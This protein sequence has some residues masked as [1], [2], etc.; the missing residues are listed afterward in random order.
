MENKYF[1][2]FFFF[3][4][5]LSLNTSAQDDE[6]SKSNI[7]TFTPSKLINKGQWDIKFFNGLY[8]QTKQTDEGSTSRTIPR[9][10]FF[11]STLEIFTGVSENNRISIGGILEFRSNT[12]NGRNAL[13]VFSFD[14][15]SGLSTIAPAIKW[16]PLENVGNFSIQTAL[17]IPTTGKEGQNEEFL[18]QSAWALQNRLFYDYT[19]PSGDWQIFTELNTEYNFGAEESFANNTLLLSPGLFLSYFPNNK[20]TV[21]VFSQHMQRL[22]GNFQQNGTS[23]GFGGKYQLTNVTNIEVLYNK[24]VRGNNFQGLGATYSIGLRFLF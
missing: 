11:T 21:L 19:F 23:L 8:T 3:A 12:F 2:L 6:D 22:F 10:N 24:F 9:Q 7:Q 16:Q 14:G 17:H 15:T 13:S 18:D 5:V 20:S 4:L 1:N